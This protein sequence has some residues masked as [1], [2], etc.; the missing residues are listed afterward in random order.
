MSIDS[1]PLIIDNFDSKLNQD[2]LFLIG[3]S[4]IQNKGLISHHLDSANNFYLNGIKQIITQGFKIQKD[5]YNRRKQTPEDIDIEWI[6][7]EVIPTDV[8]LKQP[9][10]LQYRTGKD[11]VL[12]P[13]DALAKEKIYS[14][15]LTIGCDIKA[16]AHLK[17]GTTVERIDRINNFK[18]SKVPIIKNSIMCNTYGKSREAL[19]QMGEDPSDPGGYFIVKGEWAVDCVESLAYNQPRIYINE[20]YGKSRIRCEFLSKPG[21]AYQNSE[22]LMIRY[23]NDNSLTIE[24]ARDKLKDIQIPFYLLFR[25]LGW[26]SDK[27]LLDWIVC[28]YDTEFNKQILDNIIGAINAK[29]NKVIYKSQYDQIEACKIII[30]LVPEE[31]YKNLELKTKPENYANAINDLMRI[32]DTYLLPHIGLSSESRN[33]KLQFLALLIR[34]VM[35][36]YLRYIPPTDRDGYRIK[37]IHSAGDNY[38]KVFKTFFNK[39]V[40]MPIKRRMFKDFNSAP[41]SHVNLSNMVK[42][43]IFA[44]VFER[45]I[46]QTI[47]SGNKANLKIGKKNVVNRLSAQQ[48][49]RKNQLNMLATMRQVSATSADSAKQ[50]ERASE[51]RRVH[52]STVGYI[53]VIHSPTEGEKVGINKQL[54]IFATI[55]PASSSEV[56]KKI[57]L[58][59][60]LLLNGPLLTPLSI[61]KQM[62]ARVFVNGHLIG[63]VADSINLINKYRQLRRELKIN[64]HT[65]IHWDNIQNEVHFFVDTGRVTR[66][67]IIVYNNKRDKCVNIKKDKGK[68]SESFIQGIAITQADIVGLY[69]NHKSI[70]DLLREQKIEYITPEEQENCYICHSYEQLISDKHNELHEYTHCDIPQ[71]ILGLTALTAP[72]GNHNQTPR[73]TYQTAQAKQTCGHFALNWPY[74]MDK[75]TFLQYVNEMPLIRTAANKY[76][77]PNGNNVMVAITIYTGFNQEDSIILNKAAIERGLF[78]GSKFTF[79]KTEI[80]Q[81]EELGNPDASKTE[82][83]KSA[84]YEKLVNGVVPKGTHIHED[85]VIIGKYMA[86]TKGREEKYQYSD[87]S[88]IYKDDE[89]AIVHNVIV[90]R[91]EDDVQFCKVALRKI[92]PVAIGDKFCL[93][94]DSEVLTNKGW[95][96]LTNLDINDAKVA[97][98]D[99]ITHALHY[100]NAVDKHVFDYDSDIDGK[101]Y[102]L[103]SQQINII[104][105]P[106]HRNYVK[107]D[108]Q[109]RS[110]I[111]N[112]HAINNFTL[113]EAKDIIGKLVQYKKNCINTY[114]TYEEA[115]TNLELTVNDRLPAYVWSLSMQECRQMINRLFTNKTYKTNNMELV[116]DIQRLALHAGLSANIKASSD[117]EYYLVLNT[118]L[119]MIQNENEPYVGETMNIRQAFQAEKVN[120]YTEKWIDYK[121]QVMC[122]EVPETHLFYYRENK[123]SPP[124]W[125]GNSSRSGQKGIAAL[126]MREADMPFTK[127]GI[128]P[129]ILFNAHGIPSRMTVA[130]LLESLLGNICAIKGTHIDATMFKKVD[131]ESIASELEQYG[132]NRYGY[133]RMMSGITGE[134]IDVLTFFGPTFYQRL[135]KFVADAEYSVRN[136][137]TDA[138][139]NQP[140]D[141]MGSSGGL[142]LGEMERDV[143]ASHGAS[144]F[145]HEKFFKHSDGY[146]E[147]IC[148]CGKPAIVNHESQIYKCRYCKDNAD[149]AAVPTSWTSKLFMQ[150]MESINIGI[151]R[152][153]KPHVFQQQDDIDG[154]K[155]KIDAYTDK[156][157]EELFRAREDGIDDNGMPDE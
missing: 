8:Q 148:R 141:G 133:E 140:L 72:Y 144:K 14:G 128:R 147:Y 132:L 3:D 37:R 20:G 73:V 44:D 32:L 34:K 15:S 97:T 152:T 64:P 93:K 83:L 149:I 115:R 137:L 92:R 114:K 68:S 120:N 143:L 30:G 71:A 123:L 33:D 27:E 74:R 145:L 62:L 109:H 2:D 66:P 54:A 78:D 38:A 70:D 113:I 150:E 154:I 98:M 121:G 41:F 69:T 36:V 10:T 151:R 94:P 31:Q 1:V 50:S 26:A 89:E 139:T 58:T 42:S 7:C 19:M 18:I 100:V 81:K 107:I 39:A 95:I 138:I 59:D 4:L 101:L 131:I 57:L 124:C 46:V 60:A 105:T 65:T 156:S 142:K 6:S 119:T 87:H 55:A 28:E 11:T 157:I 88:V 126:L 22:Y 116:D 136:A 155:S 61:S 111:H 129:A 146:T 43:A 67:L 135:Q 23:F 91:N 40:V 99:P 51:M 12:F 153:L 77:F 49:H 102:S 47:T 80:E 13:K 82:G 45:L 86:N 122:I 125:T 35:M 108:E 52:M 90:D 118:E 103:D 127:D 29:Y 110:N 76:I 117:A 21:D 24:I 75:E 85:D 56:L 25:A 106:N 9:T 134:H 112:A 84:N 16:I 104:C 63:Y 130:Q 17:N 48:L 96:S 5:I 53:C 79:Y